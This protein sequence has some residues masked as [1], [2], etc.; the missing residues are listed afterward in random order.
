MDLTGIDIKTFFTYGKL[1]Y[2]DK[3]KMERAR[4]RQWK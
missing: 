3:L 2:N 4:A 1:G